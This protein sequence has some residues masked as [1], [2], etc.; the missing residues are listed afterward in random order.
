MD[1]PLSTGPLWPVPEEGQGGAGAIHVP[2]SRPP[3]QTQ[4]YTRLVTANGF[5]WNPSIFEV[6]EFDC[7]GSGTYGLWVMAAS[8]LAIFMRFRE[9]SA[10]AG[11]MKQIT[12]SS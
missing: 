6:G 5:P 1:G 8:T 3:P 12:R 2:A 11:V 10:M 7:G 9:I 4:H